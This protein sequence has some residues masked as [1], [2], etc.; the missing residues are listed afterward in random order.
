MAK[1]YS[2][3][4]HGII[5]VIRAED[6]ALF[7]NH[8]AIDTSCPKK[9]KEA[10]IRVFTFCDTERYR[11]PLERGVFAGDLNLLT[12]LLAQGHTCEPNSGSSGWSGYVPFSN[13]ENRMYPNGDWQHYRVTPQDLIEKFELLK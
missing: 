12:L 7:H 6:A 5:A 9:V 4:N 8:V 10:G 1:F 13:Q 2:S 11:D 3:R